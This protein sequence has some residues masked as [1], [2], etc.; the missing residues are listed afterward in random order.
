M[1]GSLWWNSTQSWI[2]REE[3]GIPS[4][5]RPVEGSGVGSQSVRLSPSSNVVQEV[6]R[7]RKALVVD[8]PC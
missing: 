1:P 2:I 6:I 4:G 8:P 7:K 3:L 5:R